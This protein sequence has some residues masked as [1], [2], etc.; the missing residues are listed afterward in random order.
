M[1]VSKNTE[2]LRFWSFSTR[3]DPQNMVRLL[4]GNIDVSKKH[5]LLG[6]FVVGHESPNAK[7]ADF[8]VRAGGSTRGSTGRRKYGWAEVR[9]EV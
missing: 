3:N 2:S 5:V 7:G 9:A 4:R 8:E 6:D 1:F